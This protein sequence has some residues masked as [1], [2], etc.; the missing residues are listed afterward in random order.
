[1][2]RPEHQRRR[3][4]VELAKQITDDAHHQHDPDVDDRVVHLVHADDAEHDDQRIEIGVGNPQH[5]DEHADQR[6]V[7]REQHQVADIHRGDEAP[8][9]VGMLGDEL[10]AGRHAVNEQRRHQHGGHRAG[11]QAER[12]HRHE[13]AGRGRIVGRFRSGDAGDRALAELLRMLGD[14]L[15]QRVGHEARNDMR[16]ARHDADDEAQHRAARDRHRRLA[17]FLAGRQQF[18]QARRGDLG[19]DGVARRR[20]DFAEAEQPDRDRHDADA[21]AEIGNVEGVA[22]VAGHHVDADAAEQDAEGRHQQRAGERRGRHIGEEDQADDQQRGVF[23]RPEAQREGAERRRDHGQRDDAEGAGD[24]RADRGDAERGAGAAL[25]RHGVAVDA[26]HHRGGL[27]RN[28]H[29]DRGGRAAVLR[30]VIDAGQH[31][32]RLGGVE[33]ERHRQQ[34]ADAGEGADAGQHAD[35]GADHAAEKRIEQHV[36]PECDREAEHQAVDGRFHGASTRTAWAAAAISTA[37]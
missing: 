18:A 32:D 13:G 1:M 28:P 11:R 10:R 16:R 34:D 30:A 8:E 4:E 2:T 17:P 5:V 26:G 29:Q 33:A 12:Q 31:D 25:L 7:E 3:V 20:K 37:C 14:A 27:A 23:R 22:E 19:G 35:Q 9:H 24:E 6:K 15:L 36:R 21:V